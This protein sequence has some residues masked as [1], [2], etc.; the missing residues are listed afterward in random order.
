MTISSTANKAIGYGNGVATN[1]P[2]KFLIPNANQLTVILT[3]PSGNQ[4]TLSPSQYAVSGIGN[5][6]GGTVTYPLSGA[7]LPVGWSITRLRVLPIVQ[8]TDI[9]NQ[10]GFYP[11]VLESAMDYQTMTQQQLAEQQTRSIAFPVV[12]DQ[13]AIS[14]VLPAAA[15]RATKPLIFDASG[16]VVTGQQA[17][18]EPQDVLNSAQ[19]TA[20]Q[21]VAGVAPGAGTGTFLAL[22]AGAV[23]RTF[24]D[25]MRS[26]A[27]DWSDFGLVAD[28]AADNTAALMSFNAAAR[29]YPNRK[30]E[31]ML[32]AG[33]VT[34]NRPDWM[35]GVPNFALKG[36]GTILFN[37]STNPISTQNIPL[38][39]NQDLMLD[40][41]SGG[42]GGTFNP[43]YLI[44]TVSRFSSSVMLLSAGDATNFAPNTWALIHGY[45]QGSGGYP[46]SIRYF[47]YV[48][49]SSVNVNTGVVTFERPLLN[50]YRQ[51]WLDVQNNAPQ[52]AIGAARLLPLARPGFNL[53]ESAEL[54]NIIFAPSSGAVVGTVSSLSGSL[55]TSGCLRVAI[56]NCRVPGYFYPTAC[57]HVRVQDSYIE[58]SEVDKLIDHVVFEGCEIGQ[59]DNAPGC[60][61]IESYGNTFRRPITTL[62]PRRFVSRDDKWLVG[63]ISASPRTSQYIN[64]GISTA[65]DSIDIENPIIDTTDPNEDLNTAPSQAGAATNQI[66]LAS[67][68]SATDN[69]LLGYAVRILKGTGAGQY[70]QI[71]TSVGSYVGAT[72]TAALTNAWATQPDTTS[73]YKVERILPFLA[74]GGQLSIT[75]SAVN[76]ANM[77]VEVPLSNSGLNDSIIR[78]LDVGSLLSSTTTNTVIRVSDIYYNPATGRTVIAGEWSPSG[79]PL[80]GSG[81]PTVGE[82]FTANIVRHVGLRNPR[83]KGTQPIYNNRSQNGDGGALDICGMIYADDVTID[84]KYRK[85]TRLE[86]PFLFLRDFTGLPGY[87]SMLQ[88]KLLR[89]TVDVKVAYG[90]AQSA[91]T[92]IISRP[93]AETTP[94]NPAPASQTI[95]MKVAGVRVIDCS[96]AYGAQRGDTLTALTTLSTFRQINIQTNN[97]LSDAPPVGSFVFDFIP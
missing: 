27:V 21:I 60:N 29:S 22:G 72:R 55:Y 37:K 7:P 84:S 44:A 76:P 35:Q 51:D 82:V 4:T 54:E 65:V 23:A 14:P 2:H 52:A 80:S 77:T 17:Y 48:R 59:M 97:D 15:A 94:V 56:R 34:F 38:V 58:Y 68:A 46:A 70:R 83:I 24:Q 86:I 8:Q 66:I 90:G 50:K 87:L 45:N 16:N 5:R 88:A 63:D 53:C 75:I 79:T 43:G 19:V 62:G 33:M 39:I 11:D 89:I 71:A 85:P 20:E 1:W 92:A 36:A 26:I 93:S 25:K 31:L 57:Q 49:I 10:S 47:E 12:D 64:I 95:N 96:G 61:L 78:G 6:N 67:T 73:V 41:A 74:G 13:T 40:N 9:V 81:V 42:I 32:P 69:A 30:F 3:D 28:P 91:A 18:R